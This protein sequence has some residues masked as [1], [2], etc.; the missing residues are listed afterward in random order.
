LT[1]ADPLGNVNLAAGV[2]VTLGSNSR[3]VILWV[4]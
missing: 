2:T 3:W 4:Q 1:V